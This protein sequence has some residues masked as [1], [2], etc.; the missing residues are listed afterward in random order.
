MVHFLVLGCEMHQIQTVADFLSYFQSRE[1]LP[2]DSTNC[3][4]SASWLLPGYAS[5]FRKVVGRFGRL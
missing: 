1:I 5:H 4:S 3:L 2:E